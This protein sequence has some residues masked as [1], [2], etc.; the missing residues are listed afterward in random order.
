ML[1]NYQGIV[2]VTT[3]ACE[4]IDDDFQRR[5][6]VVVKFS[7]PQARERWQIRQLHLPWNH[8]VDHAYFEDIE[9]RCEMTGGQI[10]NAAF[11][12]T[13]LPLDEGSDIKSRHLS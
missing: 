8:L 6:D 7:P 4:H 11:P 5:T 12:A 9:V 2:V 1:K 10:R 3:N 13:L